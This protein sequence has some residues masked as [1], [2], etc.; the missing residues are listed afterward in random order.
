MGTLSQ[1]ELRDMF[2]F[3][4]LSAEQLTWISENGR[5]EHYP[6]DTRV[7][8]EGDPAT[9]FYVLMSGTVSMTRVV[10]GND[11][12]ITRTWQRGAYCGATQFLVGQSGEQRYAASV[13][14]ITELTF[15]SL[16]AADFAERVKTWFPMTTHLLEGM[17][18]GFRNSEASI[19][20]RQRLLALGELSAGLTHELNNPAAAAVRATEA[21]HTRVAGIREKLASLAE[22]DI[23]PDVLTRLVD[24][25]AKFV[26][27]VAHA[28]K[29]TALQASD[30]EDETTDWL[31][32]HDIDQSWELAPIFVQ[33][34]ISTDNLAEVAELIGARYLAGGLSWLAYSVETELLMGEIT[35]ATTRISGLVAA[36]KEYSHMD[37]APHQWIDVHDGLESTLVMLAGKVG[38]GVTVVR[39]Y[40]R[41]VPR[42]PAYPGALNQVWTN[43][44]DNA[45]A[46]MGP[47]GTLTIHTGQT[48]EHVV[49]EIRDTGPGIPDALKQRVFE[50]FFTT[51]PVGEGTGLG[52]DIS[53]RIVVN[54]HHGDLLVTSEPGDTR[55]QV[56]LPLTGQPG[57]S[58]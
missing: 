58:N 29:L 32:D 50:P 52:L 35:E 20:Q 7:L 28:S 26:A 54:H 39:D 51:K 13:H 22:Q 44:V 46:A 47:T 30:Q 6:P 37:R 45:L 8:A 40:D 16:P 3:E 10:G 42:V 56:L 9:C 11:I 17:Y 4:S 23:P 24:V 27:S 31:D 25:Q 21:L 5:L 41:D 43:V 2:L 33:A 14:A 49:V 55:F 57:Q 53:W 36:A 38:P 1:D 18:L 19:G 48:D 15:F 34:R 12:E